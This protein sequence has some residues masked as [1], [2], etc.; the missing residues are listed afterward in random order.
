[1]KNLHRHHIVPLHAGGSDD[2]SNIAMLT[3]EEHAEAHRL[4][5]E[6]HGR[7]QDRIAWLG[8]SGII[9]HEDAVRQ[10]Q[11]E[12]RRGKRH[13]E[14]TKKKMSD[15]A[16]QRHKE[17]PFSQ[18][19]KAK[20]AVSRSGANNPMAGKIF[21]DVHRQ[22][23]SAS[24]KGRKFTPEWCENIAKGKRKAQAGA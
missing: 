12:S 22:R 14:E 15:A 5:Y 11:A 8:L 24:L 18:E 10:V 9:G 17:K 19:S 13:S 20:M 7:W 2:A 3:V 4:L 23:L 16:K 6:Q 21:S 1:M